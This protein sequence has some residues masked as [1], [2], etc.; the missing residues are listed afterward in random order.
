MD[1][2]RDYHTKQARQ[3]QMHD[4]AYIWNPK[5]IQMNLFP[6]QKET[7]RHGKQTYFYQREKGA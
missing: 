1:G 6:K 2:L 5:M 3:R 4:I 7:Y